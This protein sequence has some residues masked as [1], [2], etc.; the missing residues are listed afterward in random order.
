MQLIENNG[1]A[2]FRSRQQVMRFD[3]ALR[4]AGMEQIPVVS[5]NMGGL[6]SNPGFKIT[7][8]M[9]RRGLFALEFGDI[10]MRCLYRMR[11]YELE[12]GSADRLHRELEKECL[13][14]LGREHISQ[15][16]YTALCRK[17]IRDDDQVA[18]DK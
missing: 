9:L 12:K 2:A 18:A 6:E 8:L 4:K 13:E 7:P 1:I 5:L 15:S 10:F 3:S 11:P 17:I 16:A 14:F